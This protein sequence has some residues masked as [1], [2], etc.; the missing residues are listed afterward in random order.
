MQRGNNLSASLMNPLNPNEDKPRQDSKKE[1][2]EGVDSA[3]EGSEEINS[4]KDKTKKAAIERH[5][6]SSFKAALFFKEHVHVPHMSPA[7]PLSHGAKL[8]L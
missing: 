2:L 1:G 3:A 8:S 7:C 5:I 4:E 6:T